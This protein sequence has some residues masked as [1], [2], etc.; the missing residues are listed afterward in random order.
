MFFLS[1][2]V[3]SVVVMFLSVCCEEFK[4]V[5]V[6]MVTPEQLRM[7]EQRRTHGKIEEIAATIDD[8]LEEFGLGHPMQALVELF[9]DISPYTIL[10]RKLGIPAPGDLADEVRYRISAWWKNVGPVFKGFAGITKKPE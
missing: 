7:E 10:T 4:A 1:F 8:V 3:V 6:D 2:I 5:V 9:E